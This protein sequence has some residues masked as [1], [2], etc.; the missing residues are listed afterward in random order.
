MQI[1]NVFSLKVKGKLLM[2]AIKAVQSLTSD[3][4]KFY[5]YSLQM[6]IVR[7]IIKACQ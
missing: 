5:T 2:S 1:E 7:I 3:S 6:R 4:G